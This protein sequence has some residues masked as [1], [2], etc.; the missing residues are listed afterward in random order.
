M[1]IYGPKYLEFVLIFGYLFYLIC[2]GTD[3]KDFILNYTQKF[4]I[5]FFSTSNTMTDGKFPFW[6]E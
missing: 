1:Y 6:K 5:C 2:G 3:T 4:V